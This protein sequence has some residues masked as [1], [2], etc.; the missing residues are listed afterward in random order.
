M[1]DPL[2][3]KTFT[4]KK[5]KDTM[6]SKEHLRFE[7]SSCICMVAVKTKR[8]K[9][10]LENIDKESIRKA[11]E[12]ID[13]GALVAFPTETVYGIACRVRSDCLARLSQLKG[14]TAEKYYTLHIARPDDVDQYVPTKSMNV[15]KMIQNAWPGPLTI[16]VELDQPDVEK[17]R[18]KLDEDVFQSLYKNNS[19]GIR[20]PDHPVAGFLLQNA[21][22]PVVAPSANLTGESPSVNGDQV[23]DRFSGHIKMVLDAG[24]TQYGINSTVVKMGKRGLKILRP[25]VYSE[26]Y[27]RNLSRIHFLFVCTGNTC[28]SPMAK[29]LFKKYLAE[30]LQADVDEFDRIGYKVD[31]AGM[32]GSVG[33]PASP[34]AIIACAAKGVDIGAHRNKELSRELIEESDF[35]YVMEPSHYDKVVAL[36]PEAANRCMML[37]E[38]GRIPDP[39][40]QPQGVYE[41]CA[42]QIERAV[43][44]R[45]SELD[46]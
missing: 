28:R 40:G 27:V 30:K 17:Q 18:E 44:K 4:S 31:S 1:D 39:I 24:P 21:L 7:K 2:S 13:S 20:C 43:N 37:D 12:M 33:F 19:I 5:D 11:A 22:H 38:N 23:F 32:I 41:R 14:R 15:Q 46:I 16:V 35:I 25:G 8:I 45:I 36:A 10:D 34:Q 29:G 9:I 42:N 6:F 3:I 26:D